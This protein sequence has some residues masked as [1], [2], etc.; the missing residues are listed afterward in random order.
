MT[1]AGSTVSHVLG[2]PEVI[3][4]PNMQHENPALMAKNVNHALERIV[5]ESEKQRGAPKPA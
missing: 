1:G 4:R 3:L 5:S 2:Y